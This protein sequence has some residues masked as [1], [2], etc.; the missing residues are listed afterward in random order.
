MT[1]LIR[2]LSIPILVLIA[3]LFWKG[4]PLIIKSTLLIIPVAGIIGWFAHEGAFS[5]SGGLA[6][7]YGLITLIG[8]LFFY[9]IGLLIDRYYLS[10]KNISTREDN[11]LLTIGLILLIA[12]IVNFLIS[13]SE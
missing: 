3:L 12:A 5:G 11:I 10:Q 8:F 13:I 2:W 9:E 1:V 6:K 7:I 4:S